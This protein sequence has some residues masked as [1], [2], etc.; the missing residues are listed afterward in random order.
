MLEQTGKGGGVRADEALKE[1]G[2]EKNKR[3]TVSCKRVGSEVPLWQS[4]LRI[5]H[6]HCSGSS[7]CCA[8]AQEF[9]LGGVAK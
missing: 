3:W 5:Q 7:H 2:G 9:P 6:C 8:L 4:G 1:L